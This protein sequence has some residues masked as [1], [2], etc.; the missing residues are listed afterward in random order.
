[1]RLERRYITYAEKNIV[2]LIAEANDILRHR[3][4]SDVRIEYR[5]PRFYPPS[6]YVAVEWVYTH[7]KRKKAKRVGRVLVTE[8]YKWEIVF[9]LSDSWAIIHFPCKPNSHRPHHCRRLVP[10]AI[11]AFSYVSAN[12]FEVC[13]HFLYIPY[14]WCFPIYFTDNSITISKT[15][16]MSEFTVSLKFEEPCLLLRIEADGLSVEK[17]FPYGDRNLREAVKEIARA[18]EISRV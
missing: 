1:M 15:G 9:Y 14:G 10:F 18:F 6:N 8:G 4:N 3:F 2:P 16:G 7:P 12:I 5:K 11:A 17:M 13:P